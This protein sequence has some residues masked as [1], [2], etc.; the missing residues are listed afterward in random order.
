MMNL[1]ETRQIELGKR[2][3]I[4]DIDINGKLE[5]IT[6]QNY[7]QE[8]TISIGKEIELFTKNS[9]LNV[10]YLIRRPN[11]DHDDSNTKEICELKTVVD[12]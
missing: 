4:N 11:H 8:L 6:I 1:K 5:T 10:S 2:I 3:D 9:K 12:Y 7:G